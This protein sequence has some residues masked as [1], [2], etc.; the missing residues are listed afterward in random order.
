MTK[1]L[2]ITKTLQKI[3]RSTDVK[4]PANLKCKDDW[5]QLFQFLDV[6]T[7]DAGND[8]YDTMYKLFAS[9]C[10]EIC[11]TGECIRVPNLGVLHKVEVNSRIMWNPKLKKHI[12]IPAG[13]RWVFKPT[14]RKK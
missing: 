8:R 1:T 2:D 10:D 11:S 3:L 12:E 6:S 4:V 13:K 9:F 5:V 14:R 7:I